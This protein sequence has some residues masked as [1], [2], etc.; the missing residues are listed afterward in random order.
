MHRALYIFGT[1]HAY[2]RPDPKLARNQVD[3]FEA[4]LRDICSKFSICLLSEEN[5]LE[6]QKEKGLPDSLPCK[7]AHGIGVSHIYC[8]PNRAQR[9]NAGIRQANDVRITG[10]FD[11][12]SEDEIATQI[13]ESYKLRERFW[14]KE[15]ERHGLWPVLL[16][17][18]A[19]HVQSLTEQAG[20]MG[21]EVHVLYEDWNA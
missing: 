15:I 5:N 12:L 10:F 11:D 13:D 17:C 16:V 18:G 6:A 21:L 20:S 19:N 7:I 4:E 2:Q 1:S 8:D 3:A 14:L 9:N